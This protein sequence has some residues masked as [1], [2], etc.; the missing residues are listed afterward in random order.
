M[1][2]LLKN[3]ALFPGTKTD[4]QLNKGKASIKNLKHC[5][6]PFSTSNVSEAI[7]ELIICDAWSQNT[8]RGTRRDIGYDLHVPMIYAWQAVG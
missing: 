8:S 5:E 6:D 7:F 3:Q 1:S 2:Y 4:G